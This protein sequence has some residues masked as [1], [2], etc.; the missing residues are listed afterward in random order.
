MDRL[1]SVT[2]SVS[3]WDS[4]RCQPSC[5]HAAQTRDKLDCL[6]DAGYSHQMFQYHPIQK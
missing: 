3:V 1:S 2:S 4:H 5:H 6:Y